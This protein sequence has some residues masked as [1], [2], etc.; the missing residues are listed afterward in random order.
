MSRRCS[1]CD[2]G[3]M[4]EVERT[5]RILYRCSNGH[6][7]PTVITEEDDELKLEEFNG[8]KIHVKVAAAVFTGEE[9]VMV[10]RKKYPFL[11]SLPFRHL[12]ADE[13]V[14]EAVKNLVETQTGLKPDSFKKFEETVI[15]NRCWRGGETH[16]WVF[17]KA[18]SEKQMLRRCSISDETRWYDRK[19]IAQ[20]LPIDDGTR[21]LYNQG[22]LNRLTIL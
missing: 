15:G 6:E 10:K 12:R 8:D 7:R 1:I 9:M 5:G 18:E 17:F 16:K 21:H 14:G 13:T 22:Y 4:E 11:Y 20:G 19:E 2:S 3:K